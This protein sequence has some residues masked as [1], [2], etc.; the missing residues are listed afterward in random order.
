MDR[1]GQHLGNYRLIRLLGE[2]A[3]ATVYLGEHI[4]LGSHAAIKILQARLVGNEL[5]RFLSEARTSAHLEHPHIVR[6]LEFGVED[7]TPFLVMSYAPQGTLRHRHPKG[8]QLSLDVI[9]SYVRQVASALQHAHATKLIHRDVKPE[10]MLLSEDGQVWLSDFGI[11]AVAHSSQS[12]ST[13]EIAGTV[14]Y[15]APEQLQGYAQPASDQYA[16]GIVIYEWLT[17][18]RPFQ[19][20]FLETATQ[21]VLRPPPP[22]HDKVP[23]VSPLVEQVV[24]TALAKDPKSRFASVQAFAHALEQAS[25]AGPFL[26]VPPQVSGIASPITLPPGAAAGQDNSTRPAASFT[27]M[28]AV[29][30]PAS[31]QVDKAPGAIPQPE[32]RQTPRSNRFYALVLLGLLG[33]VVLASLGSYFATHLPFHQGTASA[34][35]TAKP[36]VPTITEFSLITEEPAGI[37]VGPDGNIWF[38]DSDDQA[39]AGTPC[40][41]IGHMTLSGAWVPL[42]LALGQQAAS[43]VTGPDKNLWFTDPKNSAIGRMTPKYT[44]LPE[45]PLSSGGAPN[46]IT[47]GPDNNL[48]FTDDNPS[49]SNE[50]GRIGRI[51]PQGVVK[52]YSLP[53]NGS[54]PQKIT[55]GPDG[56]LWFTDTGQMAEIGRITPQ[57]K[58]TEFP[59]PRAGLDDPQGITTGPDGNVWFADKLA[60]LIG[61][62][63]PQG[64][65]TEFSLPSKTSTLGGG[66]VTGPDG[67]LWFTDATYPA[68]IGRISP[69]GKTIK[70][71]VISENAS[72]PAEIIAGPQ[73][74]L[75]FTD[76]A[77]Q[78]GRVTFGN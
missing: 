25:Q 29:A 34:T 65:I 44:L 41:D 32:Q 19:G 1:V 26:F 50:P 37:T 54:S 23:G 28:P 67:N 66:I 61:R 48:W 59:L 18:A 43:I 38:T 12:Q 62:I 31:P 4:H 52:E 49:D 40:C 14:G 74:S 72:N 24:L 22:L 42:P 76:L 53:F 36:L 56:N 33:V 51:T 47:V 70:E 45:F 7:G 63:T 75:W 58:I 21:H 5:E 39:P 64:K 13:Q 68:Q 71:F 55:V 2:G 78:I 9:L 73:N 11:A 8:S 46:D 77:D 20:S 27:T 60:N 30:A 6:V 69:D 17:G 10:N 3:F 35:P 16:L 57:G 15:M